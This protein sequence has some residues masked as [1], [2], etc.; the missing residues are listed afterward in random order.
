MIEILQQRKRPRLQLQN[1]QT[2]K[3]ILEN[4]LPILPLFDESENL[5]DE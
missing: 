5:G 3:Q 2:F 1:T 4:L